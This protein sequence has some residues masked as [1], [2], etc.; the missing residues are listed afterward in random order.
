MNSI[1]KYLSLTALLAVGCNP[2]SQQTKANHPATPTPPAVVQPDCSS[3]DLTQKVGFETSFYYEGNKFCY[4]INSNEKAYAEVLF[5]CDNQKNPLEDRAVV[6]RNFAGPN[7]GHMQVN[8]ILKVLPGGLFE[9]V[10]FVRNPLGEIRTPL[11]HAI[12]PT[13]LEQLFQDGARML[14]QTKKL[15]SVCKELVEYPAC[16]M[17]EYKPL[18]NRN[19]QKL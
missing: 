5:T 9:Y 3:L 8:L 6:I 13:N 2:S 11:P 18:Q 14:D 12:P 15:P 7:L 16:V 19:Y 4:R 10:P 1:Q 17:P